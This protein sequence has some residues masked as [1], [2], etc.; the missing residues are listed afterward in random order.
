MGERREGRRRDGGR[1]ERGLRVELW[2][3]GGSTNNS[4]AYQT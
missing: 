2:K 1:I 4:R 3:G